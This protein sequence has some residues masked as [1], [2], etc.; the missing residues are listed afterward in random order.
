MDTMHAVLQAQF[1]TKKAGRWVVLKTTISDIDPIAVAY[2]WS[3]HGCSYFVL[4]CDNTTVSNLLYQSNF[5]D[6][7]G[8][9][10]F[11]MLP[12]PQ[13]CHFLFAYL[14]IIDEHNKQSKT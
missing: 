8:N 13:V 9:V 11:K 6:D 1:G 14:H 3:Q 5:Q 2:A 10:D 4:T 7:F 12:R